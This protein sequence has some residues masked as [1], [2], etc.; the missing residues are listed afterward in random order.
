VARRV[1]DGHVA[2]SAN[3]AVISKIEPED[4]ENFMCAPG[5]IDYAVSQ[6]WY[7]PKSGEEFSWRKHFCDAVSW[8]GCARR[9]WRAMTLAAPSLAAQLDEKNLPFSVPVDKPLSLQDIAKIK[10]DHL[11]GTDMYPGD[12]ITGC[13]CNNPRRYRG[14]TFKYDGKN[15]SW[16]R[17]ISQVQCE[18]LLITQSRSWLPDE[19]GGVI[20][21][22]PA[23]PDATCLVPLYASVKEL[24]PALNVN[25]GSHHKFTRQSFWW[26]I[27]AVNTY[28]DLRF[29]DIIKDINKMQDK[30]EGQAMRDQVGIDA[31]ACELYTIDPAAAVT[32]LTN[33]CNNN[34]VAVRDAWWEFLDYLIWKY[35]M[36]FLH[37]DGKVKGLGYPQTWLPKVVNENAGDH[38]LGTD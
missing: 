16:Q 22:G 11:E 6:G 2:A 5:I 8:G 17:P 30:W 19:I 24:T 27:S 25:A 32:F 31:A 37:E 23:N 29:S 36:G 38:Y 34:V 14:R 1:P 18:Y 21:Y 28:A 12:E 26:A 15:Y 33:Y 35:N 13:P 3:N 7:D 9:V 10:R 20:W 4:T